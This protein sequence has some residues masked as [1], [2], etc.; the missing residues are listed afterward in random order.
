MDNKWEKTYAYGK[1]IANKQH[2]VKKECDK[3]VSGKKDMQAQMDLMPMKAIFVSS[4]ANL[5]DDVF[6]PEELWFARHTIPNKPVNIEHKAEDI[7]GHMTDAYVVDK[8]GER[9]KASKSVAKRDEYRWGETTD[10][11]DK[12]NHS[13]TLIIDS[14][15]NLIEGYTSW[16]NGH[17]HYIS[18]GAAKVGQTSPSND[19]H[20]HDL[21]EWSYDENTYEGTK[22]KVKFDNVVVAAEKTGKP[23][24]PN[25]IDIVSESVL[26]SLIFPE[27]VA[28][29]IAEAIIGQ[30]FVSMETYFSGYDYMLGNKIIARN[31]E[32]LFLDA[33]LRSRG[34]MG[35]F[36]GESVKRILRNLHFG[37]QGIV[38]N[39]ANPESVILA[40]KAEKEVVQ[41]DLATA[42][43]KIERN[44][45]LN[46]DNQ[47]DKQIDS[48]ISASEKVGENKNMDTVKQLNDAEVADIKKQLAEA[49]KKIEELQSAEVQ[50]EITI[51]KE[52]SAKLA[53]DLSK[54]DSELTE[55]TKKLAEATTTLEA[56]KKEAD[57]SKKELADIKMAQI[58]AKRKSDLVK[59]DISEADLNELLEEV[60]SKSDDEYTK[61]LSRANRMFKV[62]S[63][64]KADA[65]TDKTVASTDVKDDDK[66]AAD[67]EKKLE[68]AVASKE[69]VLFN[70][71]DVDDAITAKARSAVEEIFGGKDKKETK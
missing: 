23:D 29:I 14:L 48:G 50:K 24:I 42:L 57:A 36:N 33:S 7:R 37:G 64:V 20:T 8:K 43:E 47:K 70:G 25:D 22:V 52:T 54:K 10:A 53:A 56:V 46:R 15:G 51:L 40:S 67:A 31:D 39:P 12:H 21:L 27:E 9:V 34:G 3:I 59:F 60:K 58:V 41:P 2:S 6:M 63:E 44:C 62:K 35:S 65:K 5:N 66:V 30:K 26:Y 4:G 19:G 16:D 17:R 71:N 61:F 68:T 13:W 18:A 69:G 28:K 49:N 32:T 1:I 45:V 38:D 55:V 11:D